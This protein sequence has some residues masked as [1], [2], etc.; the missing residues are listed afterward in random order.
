[1]KEGDPPQ[2][3]EMEEM[4]LYKPLKSNHPAVDM[5]YRT[6]G[7]LVYGLQVSRQQELTSIIKT[8]AVD[9]WLKEIGMKNNMD[10]VRIAVIPRSKNAEESKAKY[11]RDVSGYPQLEL[12]KLPPEYGQQF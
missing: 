2:Y 9:K 11:D 8:R 4:V 3:S 6:K 5:M 7:G 10:L 1:M 12:W